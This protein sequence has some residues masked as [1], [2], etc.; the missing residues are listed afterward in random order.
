[1]PQ[2]SDRKHMVS[3]PD[4]DK[5]KPL[6]A[7]WQGNGLLEHYHKLGP[8]AVCAAVLFGKDSKRKPA[9]DKKN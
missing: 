5:G 2:P 3:E 8:S 9:S 1:M 7:R 4:G 6:K